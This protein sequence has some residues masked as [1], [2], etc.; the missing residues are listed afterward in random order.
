MLVPFAAPTHATQ[1]HG[2][3][4]SRYSQRTDRNLGDSRTVCGVPNPRTSTDRR[5]ARGTRTRALILARAV[6]IASAEGL[7]NVS[8]ARLGTELQLSKSGVSGHFVSRQG[9][10]LA[11]VAVAARLY[12]ERVV[13]PAMTQRAGIARV[14]ALCEGWIEFMRS[15]ELAGR[16]FFLT[17]LVEF[18]ARPGAVRNALLRYRRRWEQ[19]F[20]DC[21]R[22]AEELGEV[23]AGVDCVQLFFEIAGLI[24]VATLD[25][26]LRDDPSVF[27]RARTG[28]LGRL[29]PLLT[30][31]AALPR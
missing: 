10:Q 21:W 1:G 30:D 14:W 23:R 24:T 31:A 6:D 27:D 17:A 26:Q 19:V 8:L 3:T 4:L 7:D 20:A 9:L 22:D 29:Q 12:A 5:R 16:S 18:D 2:D 11:V 28:V 15:G 25:S 13:V